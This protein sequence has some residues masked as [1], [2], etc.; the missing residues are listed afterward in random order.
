MTSLPAVS[1]CVFLRAPHGRSEALGACLG[2]LARR[3]LEAPGCLHCV[4]QP[5]LH[6]EATWLLSAQWASEEASA[7]WAGT[8]GGDWFSLLAR[9]G[10]VIHIDVQTFG[11]AVH[12]EPAMRR[13]S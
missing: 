8:P 5:A 10:L 11:Q 6:D 12:A 2:H 4:A 9:D 7:A 1:H 3:T 13:A